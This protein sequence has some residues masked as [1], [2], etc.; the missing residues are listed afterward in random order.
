MIF[1][2]HFIAFRVRTFTEFHLRCVL[3]C[4]KCKKMQSIIDSCVSLAH[5]V[6]KKFLPAIFRFSTLFYRRMFVMSKDK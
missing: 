5:S 6:T 3:F 1:K 4:K 2:P